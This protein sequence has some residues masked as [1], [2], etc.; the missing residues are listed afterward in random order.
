MQPDSATVVGSPTQ[1]LRLSL[2]RFC[3]TAKCWLAGRRRSYKAWSVADITVAENVVH[4]I[5]D[6]I[7]MLQNHPPHTTMCTRGT[8]QSPV[9]LGVS[10]RTMNTAVGGN[11]G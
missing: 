9:I 11:P 3:L 4:N 6:V 2:E 5:E 10:Q 1:V 8:L 7:R